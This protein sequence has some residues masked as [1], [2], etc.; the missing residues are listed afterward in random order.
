MKERARR[1]MKRWFGGCGRSHAMLDS[2]LASH[3]RKVGVNA[4]THCR[5]CACSMCQEDRQVVPP[6]RERAFDYAD[7]LDFAG[8][9]RSGQTWARR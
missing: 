5:P 7:E 1:L 2:F 6:M 8:H 3:P 9:T 4:S